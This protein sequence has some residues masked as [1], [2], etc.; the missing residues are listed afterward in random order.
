MTVIAFDGKVVAADSLHLVNEGT[1]VSYRESGHKIFLS[2]C[3]RLIVGITGCYLPKDSMDR[4]FNELAN[5]VLV[6][7]EDNTGV[8]DFPTNNVTALVVAR[9]QHYL[10]NEGVLT[11]LESG[12][13]VSLGSGENYA[14]I[15]LLAGK[16]ARQAVELAIRLD[17]NCGGKIEEIRVDSLKYF[18]VHEPKKRAKRGAKK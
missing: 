17:L 5:H 12:S 10:L 11:R 15:A 7:D 18:K 9:H 16:T 14:K 2:P 4:L 13:H 1:R 8:V 6:C 3:K